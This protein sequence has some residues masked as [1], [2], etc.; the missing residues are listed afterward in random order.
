[1]DENKITPSLD[2]EPTVAI[3]EDEASVA[4]EES[5]EELTEGLEEPAESEL[6][7]ESEEELEEEIPVSK[8]KN[9]S[10]MVA[11]TS[12]SVLLVVAIVCVVAIFI[13]SNGGFSKKI[14]YEKVAMTFGSAE[15]GDLIE[16]T[17]GEFANIFYTTYYELYSQY[18]SYSISV[19]QIKEQAKV[20]TVSNIAISAGIYDAAIKAGYTLTEEDKKTVESEMALFT[21][22][23]ESASMEI[24]DYM[25]TFFGK[26]YDIKYIRASTEK[27]IIVNRYIDDALNSIDKEYE[28]E[29]GKNKIETYYKEN[30]A[31]YDVADVSYFYL[32]STQ[33]D[34][35]YTADNIIKAVTDGATFADAIKSVTGDDKNVP[36]KLKG[37]LTQDAVATAVTEDAAKWVFELDDNGEYVNKEGSVKKVDKGAMIYILYV[38]SEPTRD[39]SHAVTLDYIKV[40]IS[41]DDSALTPEALKAEA[42]AT[43]NSI[44]ADFEETDKSS[45]SFS[46]IALIQDENDNALVSGDY[47]ENLTTSTQVD[48]AVLDWAFAAERN[49]SDYAI[50]ECED[51]YY[52]VFYREKA[53]NAVWFDTVKEIVVDEHKT[54]WSQDLTNEYTSAVVEN[55][56]VI[57]EV[58]DNLIEKIS[59]NS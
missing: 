2:E 36:S 18:A 9:K 13:K 31:T 47:F 38:N 42:K 48:Q 49:V 25:A 50:I 23:A 7:E 11:I 39:E 26:G 17:A 22:A 24:D 6:E 41:T 4:V 1:M 40:D 15:T 21:D 58:I 59:E 37:S 14:D 57:N 32:D 5:E 33:T 53:E 16:I 55:E 46:D 10:T 51:C 43:I 29:E 19:D 35:D 20:S 12:L 44:L 56:D 54:N 28:G 34:A 30:K 52:L 45:D 27:A 8:K 3:E